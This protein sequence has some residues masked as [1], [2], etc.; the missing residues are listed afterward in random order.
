MEFATVSAM[1]SRIVSLMSS[2]SLRGGAFLTSARNRLM[3]SPARLPALDDPIKGLPNLLRIRRLH[4][5]PAQSGLCVG[6]H[7]GNRLVTSWA[8]SP[9]P[10]F[11]TSAPRM[12]RGT[13]EPGENKVNITVCVLGFVLPFC[14]DRLRGTPWTIG[15]GG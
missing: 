11:F 4:I 3:T 1:T 14:G 7:C 10:V 8:M 13:Y 5:E 2:W 12:R 6:D 15:S 9:R